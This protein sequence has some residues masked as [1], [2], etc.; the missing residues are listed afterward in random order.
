[1]KQIG[2]TIVSLSFSLVAVFSPLIFMS[3]IVGRLFREFAITLSVAVL[4]SAIVSLTLTPMMCSRLLEAEEKQKHGRL[5]LASDRFFKGMLRAYERG[6]QWVL[7]HQAFT[8]GVAAVTLVATIWL[9]V[10]VP[11]GLLPQ[12]DTGLILGITDAAQSISFKA[13]VQRQRQ[14][15]ERVS[16]DPDVA[17]VAS[18]VGGGTV[19]ATMNTGRLYIG[20]KRRDDRLASA[21]EI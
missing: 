18:F 7:R 19:N 21:T 2:F 11:K 17:Y 5:F 15:S 6:L 13:M 9:Y 14:I 1:A 12:Q 3:G 8:L 16:K 20:L 4:V 10:I